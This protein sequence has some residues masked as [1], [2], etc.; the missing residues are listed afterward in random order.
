MNSDLLTPPPTEPNAATHGRILQFDGLRALAFLSVFVNHATHLPLLW[1]GVDVFFVLSGFLITGILLERK[2]LGEAYFSYFYRRR[3]VRILP[4]YLLAIVLHGVLITWSQ[5][6]PLWLFILAPNY[7]GLLPNGPGLLPLW[8]LAVEEQFYFVWP[9]VVLLTTEKTLL[10]IA[11]GALVV[12]PI[13]RMVCTPFVP[14][15]FYIY[16]LTPFRADLLC[17]GAALTLL[18]KRRDAG[19]VAAVR[20]WA[21]LV[22]LGG[23]FLFAGTQAFPAFRLAHN[24]PLANGFV[25]LFSLIGGTGLLA[26]VLSD[27]GWLRRLLTL[28]PLR[29]LGEISY[30]MYLV[31][32]V[33]LIRLE[34]RFGLH[35]WVEVLAFAA[36]VLYATISWF[37]MERPLIRLAAR[38]P[39]R[40]F[41]VPQSLPQG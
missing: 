6:K 25:Y 10:R 12:V 9:F 27:T 30:T 8:S 21:W 13:L 32:V 2:R 19:I 31:H 41:A 37:L 22:C 3:I 28:A 38:W 34:L 40:T 17:A 35:P 1:A 14:N 16:V 15:M 39:R 7:Q 24:T 18:W 4:A 33:I 5:Y 20:R 23:F 26:W 36:I 11:L 29:Y